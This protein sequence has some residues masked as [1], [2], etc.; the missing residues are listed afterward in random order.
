[1]IYNILD[2]DINII[3]NSLKQELNNFKYKRILITGGCGFIGYYLLKILGELNVEITLIDN[4]SSKNTSKDFLI[5]NKDSNIKFFDFDLSKQLPENITNSN[6]DLIIHLAGIPSPIYYMASPLKTID[7]A[8]NGTRQLLEMSKNSGSKFIFF[9]SSEIYGDPPSNKVPTSEDYRGNVSPM[10]PRACYDESKRL[11]ETLCYTFN[12]KYSVECNII[13][14]FNFYGPGMDVFDYR[15]VPSFTLNALRGTSLKVY[16]DGK[17][18][19]TFCYITDAITGI[20]LVIQKGIS[21]EAYN[22]GVNAKQEISMINLAK[23]IKQLTNS[24]SKIEIIKHPNTYPTDDPNRRAPDIS[25]AFKDLNYID[26]GNLDD[27]LLKFCDWAK[28]NYK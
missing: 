9:S 20:F 13:R 22:I 8:I 21:G 12:T 27:C 11:A 2:N 4:L 23:K 15:V 1:M 6:Y 10:G 25:K 14:P 17:Q 16:G 7:I 3:K 5:D 26:S 28:E 19:R 18:T 24:N